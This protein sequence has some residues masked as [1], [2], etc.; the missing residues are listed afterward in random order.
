[1]RVGLLLL[2][3]GSALKAATMVSKHV[4]GKILLFSSAPPT[5]GEAVVKREPNRDKGAA[6]TDRET[7]LL[8]PA[9]DAYQV[10][11]AASLQCF[12]RKYGYAL[13]VPYNIYVP[14]CVQVHTDEM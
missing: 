10:N 11:Y 7:D 6:A 9:S 4:G 2:L 8:K 13:C 12:R 14:A 1:M 5:V 3:Q